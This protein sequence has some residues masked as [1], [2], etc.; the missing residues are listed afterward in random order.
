M[1]LPTMLAAL[2]A[3]ADPYPACP[4]A[5]VCERRH[6]AAAD[7]V[8]SLSARR[9]DYRDYVGASSEY[10]RGRDVLEMDLADAEALRC[11]WDHVWWVRW[12]SATPVQRARHAAAAR[13]YL[14]DAL[15]FSREW[16]K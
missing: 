14:G 16:W 13:A 2:L 5:H 12:G 10:L 6:Q 11:F 4:P 8:L 1:L 9:R 7:L 3:A 15:W